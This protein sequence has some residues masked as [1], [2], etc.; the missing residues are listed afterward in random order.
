MSGDPRDFLVG[1]TFAGVDF[2]DK[3][4]SGYVYVTDNTSE[5]QPVIQQFPRVDWQ[6]LWGFNNEKSKPT[7]KEGVE[8]Q[9]LFEVYLV[10][11][12]NRK[13][14]IVHTARVIASSEED[15]K[16]KSGLY[17]L[18]QKEWEADFVTTIVRK[19]GDVAVKERAKEVKQV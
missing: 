13:E 14:P 10:Y 8:M 12:E 3:D 19:I 9:G 1:P 6:T 15:A 7:P 2:G 17:P 4:T 18:I 5:I 11:G 16:V